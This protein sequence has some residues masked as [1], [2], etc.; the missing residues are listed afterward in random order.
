MDP[1]MMFMLA[2][3]LQKMMQP[4]APIMPG[5]GTPPPA[6]PTV[7]PI[8]NIPTFT[9]DMGGS[10][11]GG[12]GMELSQTMAPQEGGAFS[13]GPAPALTPS[14]LPGAAGT[15]AAANP[16]EGLSRLGADV[17][18]D[19]VAIGR[20]LLGG[21]E[22]STTGQ[23]MNEA[24]AVAGMVD[25]MNP[26]A[27]VAPPPVV[28]PAPAPGTSAISPPGAPAVATSGVDINSLFKG[29]QGVKAPPPVT[30]IM[31]GGNTGGARP[32]EV[33]A[34][35]GQ[36]ISGINPI[37]QLLFGGGAPKGLPVQPL[38]QLLRGA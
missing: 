29:L 6:P 4:Q 25:P 20:A 26:E 24:A 28:P 30:P 31:H 32:P 1:T 11:P 35:I 17:T 8:Q 3:G 12:P 37:L 18:Q 23:G 19:D 38:G 10:V 15:P 5:A 9:G 2:Q 33:T 22:L 36:Q 34:K 7:Q 13:P 14:A 27:A 16:L 21:P